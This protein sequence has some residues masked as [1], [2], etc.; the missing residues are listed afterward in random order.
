MLGF[1]SLSEAAI[2]EHSSESG[3]YGS[4]VLDFQ[5]SGQG[6]ITFQGEGSFQTDISVSGEGEFIFKGPGAF[7]VDFTPSGDGYAGIS[8]AA[9]TELDFSF[10]GFGY[11]LV[12]GSSA[13]TFDVAPEGTGY[14]PVRGTGSLTLEFSIDGESDLSVGHGAFRLE[15]DPLGEGHRGAGG[16]AAFTFPFTVL[17]AG[18]SYIPSSGIF[19]LAF[20]IYGVGET[21]VVPHFAPNVASYISWTR[22]LRILVRTEYPLPIGYT[23][24][25]LR[26]GFDYEL[27]NTDPENPDSIVEVDVSTPELTKVS[28]YLYQLED[29]IPLDLFEPSAS[30]YYASGA[31]LDYTFTIKD[32]EEVAQAVSSSQRVTMFYAPHLL[33][34][35]FTTSEFWVKHPTEDEAFWFRPGY[36]SPGLFASWSPYYAKDFRLNGL[37][38]LSLS[39]SPT[40]EFGLDVS[41]VRMLVTRTA[42][43]DIVSW[44]EDYDKTL[45][46]FTYSGDFSSNPTLLADVAVDSNLWTLTFNAEAT[47]D[48]SITLSI[49]TVSSAYDPYSI[50][51]N[52]PEDF[53]F[54]LEMTISYTGVSSTSTLE[55]SLTANY[56][57]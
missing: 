49:V 3:N 6:G 7:E 25:A 17:G 21:E 23:I 42:S 8:G 31:A 1:G 20:Q 10:T 24:S 14:G 52:F 5:I 26:S 56:P 39:S 34:Q 27:L 57:V 41:L 9:A 54:Q 29:T 43:G 45:P 32:E 28:D 15:F 18:N 13:F 36:E 30:P 48:T 50:P 2:S 35:T 40:P 16:L 12:S 55:Y 47:V 44:E 46:T 53:D 33:A 38:S 19:T 22:V 4:F 11:A 51:P 37:V